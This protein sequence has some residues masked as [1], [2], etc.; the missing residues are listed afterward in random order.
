MATIK[1]IGTTVV[2]SKRGRELKETINLKVDQISTVGNPFAD[3]YI[4]RANPEGNSGLHVVSSFELYDNQGVLRESFRVPSALTGARIAGIA[5]TAFDTASDPG[6]SPG[7]KG[8]QDLTLGR[9]NWHVNDLEFS[10][11]KAVMEISGSIDSIKALAVIDNPG[12]FIRAYDADFAQLG[13]LRLSF[14]FEV[15]FED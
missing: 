12:N 9:M 1:I 10:K 13:T 7:P 5:L 4:E 14:D 3:F 15:K 8:V 2:F 11:G 6:L